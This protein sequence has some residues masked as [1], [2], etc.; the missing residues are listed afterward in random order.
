[1]IPI[2]KLSDLFSFT[3]VEDYKGWEKEQISTVDNKYNKNP[4]MAIV[5]SSDKI[6]FYNM[7]LRDIEFVI[8]AE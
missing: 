7:V 1:M 2:E 8:Y 4:D 3:F 5:D 6:E